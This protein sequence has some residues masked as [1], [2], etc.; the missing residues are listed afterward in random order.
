MGITGDSV[1]RCCQVDKNLLPARVN[2][3][4]A[5]I[6]PNPA[7]LDPRFLRY[8]LISPKMQQV[9]LNLASAGATRNALTKGMIESLEIPFPYIEK[10]RAIADI[11]G[12]L[13]D[14]IELN[15]HISKTLE[16]IANTLFKS[17]FIDFDP[18]KAKAAE[19][20]PE[21][22]SPEIAKLF[23]D[24]FVDSSLGKIPKGWKAVQFGKLLSNTLGGDWGDENV[25]LDNSVMVAVLRG[26]DIPKIKKLTKSDIPIRFISNSSVAK[27]KLQNGDIVIEISGGTKSQ[28][29]GRST[30]INENLL[31]WFDCPII[32]ASFCRLF[33]PITPEYSLFLSCYLNYIYSIGKTW[34]YQN[35]STGISNFQTTIFLEKESLAFPNKELLNTFNS[36]INP[37]FHKISLKEN[38]ILDEIKKLLLPKLIS[39]FIKL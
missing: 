25:N 10:Q 39:G 19:R 7:K 5:I 22:L 31:K 30:Y 33:R 32:P 8:V 18:V 37:F 29:T 2:Q 15:R 38:L 13:D 27:R 34:S 24:S 12:C 4:V 1:A 26:T 17:W 23:P 3:H 21:G 20:E 16:E 6:R 35:Q 36:I 28:P 11:L 9:L 14:K